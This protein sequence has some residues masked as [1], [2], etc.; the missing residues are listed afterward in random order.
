MRYMNL[1]SQSVQEGSK[2]SLD[3]RL[4]DRFCAA[5]KQK[6]MTPY[7]VCLKRFQLYAGRF[8]IGPEPGREK[9]SEG[10]NKAQKK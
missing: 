6:D 3:I 5:F 10:A 2:G 7:S 9:G 4:K 1:I 8:K